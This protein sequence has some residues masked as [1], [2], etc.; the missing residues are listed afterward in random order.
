ME[1]HISE[2]GQTWMH[3]C[4]FPLRTVLAVKFKC[5]TVTVQCTIVFDIDV[6]DKQGEVESAFQ[7]CHG[8]TLTVAWGLCN[9]KPI[10]H[11]SSSS[12]VSSKS[13]FVLTRYHE[14]RKTA[15]SRTEVC[16]I[17]ASVGICSGLLI[18]HLLAPSGIS[19]KLVPNE[20]HTQIQ[21]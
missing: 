3:S 7:C 9:S 19:L 11:Y 2:C 5:C 1:E 21:V 14:G 16:R 12:K 18:S 15:A 10:F 6:S 4:L 17:A 20:T 13:W 8:T